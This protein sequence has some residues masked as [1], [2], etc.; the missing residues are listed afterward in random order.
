[1]TAHIPGPDE[2]LAMV[3]VAVREFYPDAPEHID[4]RNPHHA[5]WE[6]AWR[7]I[8]AAILDAEANRIY[9]DAYP[10]APIKID[11]DD[12]EHAVW[13]ERWIEIQQGLVD[14]APDLPAVENTGPDLSY[15]RE[16]LMMGILAARPLIGEE[17]AAELDALVDEALVEV[18]AAARAQ[19]IGS[20]DFFES[21]ASRT[22]PI[23]GRDVRFWVAVRWN[24]ET[25]LLRAHLATDPWTDLHPAG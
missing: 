10:D 14:N 13:A 2:L 22:L 23:E 20:D 16:S 6:S 15:A 25:G 11:P 1:M 21:V 19:L 7:G 9:W 12:P 3:D 8:R 5:E 17:L 18:D 24:E 4:V